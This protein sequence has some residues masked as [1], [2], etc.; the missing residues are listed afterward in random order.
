MVRAND[1]V[2]FAFACENRMS[3]VFANVVERSEHPVMIANDSNWIACDLC[4]GIGTG[5]PDFL[6]MADPLPCLCDDLLLIK[7]EPFRVDISL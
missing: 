4:G 3:A 1:A 7:L 2:Y 6:D 5:L